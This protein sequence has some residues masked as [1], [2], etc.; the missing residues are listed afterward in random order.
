M[1]IVPQRFD[2]EAFAP[3]GECF[4]LR[5]ERGETHPF[6][7]AMANGRSHATLN[8]SITRA[9]AT[10][11]PIKVTALEKHD[12]SAQ[13]FAPIVVGRWLSAVAPTLPDGGPDFSKLRA[14]VLDDAVGVC[15][16]PNVWHHPFACFD[17]PAEMLMLRWDDRTEADTT[18]FKAPADADIEI[19]LP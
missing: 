17:G 5:D 18:W 2:P 19:A 13:T 9:R 10:T 8:V 11:A 14:F 16:R 7:A 4:A 1:R 12:A 15:Y 3:Y 6:A